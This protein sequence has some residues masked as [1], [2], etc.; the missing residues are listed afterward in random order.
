MRLQAQ[1][2]NQQEPH[3]LDVVPELLQR[4]PGHNHHPLCPVRDTRVGEDG[5]DFGDVGHC[6]CG[7]RNEAVER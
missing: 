2:R 5:A 3:H 1:P 4:Q 6:I 7:A